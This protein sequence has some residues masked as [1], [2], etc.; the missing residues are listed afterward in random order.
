M[1]DIR[2]ERLNR[3]KRF[4]ICFILLIMSL[5]VLFVIAVKAGS[6]D[7]SWKDILDSL[8]DSSTVKGKIVLNI[9]MPRVIA[10]I[11]LG[12]AL[13]IAGFL[14]QSFFNNPI[15][16]PFVLG[17]SSSAKLAVAIVMI[18]FIGRGNTVGSYVMVLAAFIGALVSMFF[19]LLISGRTRNSAILIVCG[20]MIGYICSAITELL[21]NFAADSD[22]V[23]LHSWSMGSFSGI[24]WENIRVII[25]VVLAGAVAAFLM[26]KHIEAY[27]FG[28]VYARSMGVNIKMFR[29]VIIIISSVLSACVTAFAGPVSFLGVAVPHLMKTIF[30]SAKPVVM[31]PACFLGGALFALFSDLMARILFAPTEISVS[32]ITSILGAPVIIIIMLNKKRRA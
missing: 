16:G 5:L 11:L 18:V 3:I 20:V 2:D 29:M 6:I 13:G 32:T 30:K 19:I 10:A 15:A 22:I 28:E 21:I 17:I 8:K 31:I 12:G 7:I 1:S 26:S 23:N 9:R 4:T 25:V 24:S 14:L 27:S